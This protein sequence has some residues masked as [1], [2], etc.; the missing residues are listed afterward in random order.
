MLKL[1]MVPT[2]DA[3]PELKPWTPQEAALRWQFKSKL[4]TVQGFGGKKLQCVPVITEGDEEHK[5]AGN[6][7]LRLIRGV[8]SPRAP[9]SGANPSV[10]AGEKI[11]V[12]GAH[13]YCDDVG[14]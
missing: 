10:L 7:M 4:L 13:D 2:S 9:L 14:L 3:L 5:T 1:V 12:E 6:I 11:D 8:A